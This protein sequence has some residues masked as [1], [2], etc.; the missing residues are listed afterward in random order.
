[1]SFGVPLIQGG[2]EQ[3][4]TAQ[5]LITAV[6]ICG[7]A[8]VAAQPLVS[9][10]TG[11]SKVTVKP[12]DVNEERTYWTNE[13]GEI[14][15]GM[16]ETEILE[17]AMPAAVTTIFDKVIMAI[18]GIAGFVMIIAIVW[19]GIKLQAKLAPFRGKGG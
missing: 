18:K 3:Q 14:N 1:M 8:I 9:W 10:I 7:F 15:D 17:H 5:K 2:R 13:P 4:E 12:S 11:F 6:I 19:G 16:T